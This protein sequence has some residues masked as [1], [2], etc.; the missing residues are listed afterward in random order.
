MPSVLFVCLGNIC[1]SSLAEGVARN[2]ANKHGI[3]ITI[4]SA[5][6]SRYHNG[7]PPCSVSTNLARQHGIDIG[8]QRSTHISA[9]NLSSFDRIIAMDRSNLGD[10]LALGL[11]NVSLLGDYGFGGKEVADLYY[12]PHR[13]EEVYG[14]IE[15]AVQ[16]IFGEMGINIA[17]VLCPHNTKHIVNKRG[18]PSRQICAV[19]LPVGVVGDNTLR[20]KRF[21]KGAWTLV[22]QNAPA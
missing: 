14:M 13:A 21:Q 6:T 16:Q 15:G 7:E 1:R 10:L 20:E 17:R 12:E 22:Q 8:H 5:G 11:T 2:L 19:L 4:V 3:D 9:Y 18:S